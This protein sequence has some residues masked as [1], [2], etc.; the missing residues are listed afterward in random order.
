MGDLIMDDS[1]MDDLI[2]DEPNAF[3][4]PILYNKEVKKLS[5]TTINDL[6]LVKCND[7]SETPIY[8]SI[9]KNSNK[10]SDDMLKQLTKYYTTDIEFLKQTQQLHENIQI[11]ELKNGF[12][13]YEMNDVDSLLKEIRDDNGFCE[14]YLYLDWKFTKPLNYN[15]LFLQ[16]MSLY[17][18]ASPLI[19]LF[20]PIIVLI[21]PFFIIKLRG[22]AL[23]ISQYIQNFFYNLP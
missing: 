10:A 17:N 13:N 12:S 18:I 15:P 20:L 6:E 23:T 16:L 8:Y 4:I 7:A 9:F 14:K 11:S 5:E 22:M 1:I 2:I 19:S 21:V 3:K